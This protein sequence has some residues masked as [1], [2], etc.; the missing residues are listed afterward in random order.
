MLTLN[1]LIEKKLPLDHVLTDADKVALKMENVGKNFS[2]L[3]LMNEMFC[4][5]N[6]TVESLLRGWGGVQVFTIGETKAVETN[7]VYDEDQKAWCQC[8]DDHGVK[9]FDDGHTQYYGKD[10]L[11]V[12]KHH[13]ACCGCTKLKQIG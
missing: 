7:S 6:M 11:P 8:D 9:F 2:Y 3:C 10:S 1:Y 4:Y 13:Y 12:S 5:S